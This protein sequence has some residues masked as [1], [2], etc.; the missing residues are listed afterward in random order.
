[1]KAM[2]LLYLTPA[3][4]PG[5]GGGE[6]YVRAL[7][8]ELA[9]QG[10]DLTV[11][12]SAAVREAD[13][14]QG[15]A[16]PTQPD[17]EQDGRISIHRLPIKPFPGGRAG[18]LAW[19]KGM[20]LLSALPGDHSGRLRQMARLI[21]PIVGLDSYLAKLGGAFDLVH[22]FNISWEYPL[23]AAWNYTR[24]NKLPLVV[25]PFAH[26]GEEGRD[27]VARNSA[28]QHQRQIVRA[29]AGVQA[30]TAV[31][32]R[33]LIAIGV[34]PERASAVGSG[35]DPLPDL[36]EGTA[37][38]QQYDL[39]PP[40]ALF[41]GRQ[42]YDKGAIQAAQAVLAASDL[43]LTLVLIG[44]M[45]A[46][47]RRFYGRLT[48]EEQ[49][50]VRPL[51]R[52]SESVKHT[53]LSQA[54]MLLLPSRADSFGIVILEAWAYGLPVIG[55]R[56][57]GI[58][59]V[60]EHEQDGLLAPFGDVPALTAAIRRLLADPNLSRA[61]GAAGRQKAGARFTWPN[62]ARAVLADYE[63]ILRGES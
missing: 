56:A 11:V 36:L 21:P 23:T 48:P 16:A 15:T 35:R 39:R 53:L 22:A 3:Y 28:M 46:D 20:V 51:G 12:T 17:Q 45:S 58:P 10:C 57:G 8:A 29:A 50:R 33:Q 44:D 26:F 14:W 25:T 30:L 52:L 32:Q 41:I 19:R 5:L 24:Q 61:L 34:A 59:G 7:A 55:A 18:L 6:R 49:R 43:P 60:I 4:P 42:N 62:V 37:V 27:R 54:A 40:L 63:R 31:E 47:F 13:F 9:D 2:R 38:C 1:M